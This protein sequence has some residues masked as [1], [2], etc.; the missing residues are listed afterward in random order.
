[1]KRGSFLGFYFDND[2]ANTVQPLSETTPYA[3][4]DPAGIKSWQ[5]AG[6]VGVSTGN[7]FNSVELNTSPIMEF[8]IQTNEYM[9]WN[10][11]NR[12][13]GFDNGDDIN[14]PA[15]A[16][17]PYYII[18]EG[19]NVPDGSD[20][21]LKFK[22]IAAT[23]A[24]TVLGI[25]TGGGPEITGCELIF[26]SDG[27]DAANDET[28]TIDDFNSTKALTG[29]DGEKLN[30]QFWID[31]VN[32][33][34]ELIYYNKETGQGPTGGDRD[35]QHIS[36]TD[37]SPVTIT[38]TIIRRLSVT[39]AGA[40]QATIDR[41]VVCRKPILTLYDSFVSMSSGGKIVLGRIG[42]KLDDPGVF[43]QQRYGICG[44]IPVNRIITDNIVT[45]AK[46]RWNDANN[47]QDLVGYRDVIVCVVV[48]AANNFSAII[49]DATAQQK[50]AHVLG[51]VGVVVGEALD[52]S[53]AL[54]GANECI[55]VGPLGA[56]PDTV[57]S[58]RQEFCQRLNQGLRTLAYAA[59]TPFVD[60]Y[61]PHKVGVFTDFAAS[62]NVHPSTSACTTIAEKIVDAYEHAQVPE[63]FSPVIG[64]LN[65]D[66]LL[67]MSDIA[68]IAS[69]WLECNLLSAEECL[70]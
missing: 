6:N 4:A 17:Q 40:G 55:I 21:A 64:D 46:T 48:G 7:N 25:N 36:I 11:N 2:P 31:P 30:L 1:M 51:E 15:F 3:P 27:S 39:S 65:N 62:D 57:T 68:I 9:P 29:Q 35:I 33:K 44:G 14:L 10:D 70:D 49:S 66:C 59:N 32:D 67:D 56:P 50:A 43:T 53:D 24:D 52:A 42:D 63:C 34:M 60:N 8:S 18:M 61:G 69:H 16:D 38:D 41:I 22:Y 54:G 26:D 47:D 58:Y 5:K 37:R 20:L 45:A 23:A 28:I 13:S 19:V 12:G